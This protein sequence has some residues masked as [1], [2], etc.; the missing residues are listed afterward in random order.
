MGSSR[1]SRA[2]KS[3]V[4]NA[5]AVAHAAVKGYFKTHLQFP[6]LVKQNGSNNV[7]QISCEPQL[8]ILQGQ[9]NE[10][11]GSSRSNA[12]RHKW[13]NVPTPARVLWVA[14]AVTHS[15][16]GIHV[17]TRAPLPADPRRQRG[18]KQWSISLLKTKGW[19]INNPPWTNQWFLFLFF[20]RV[21][22]FSEWA[23][24]SRAA[25]SRCARFLFVHGSASW[26]RGTSRVETKTETKADV[27]KT[28]NT[29][30]NKCSQ[31]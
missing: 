4:G 20:F 28:H 21:C 7:T 26:Q 15:E 1:R 9:I 10:T 18:R 23:E 8:E 17:S 6:V 16:L 5:G 11:G 19:K 27:D 12:P 24:P 22:W 3:Q 13:S 14:E 2:K 29:T 31:K 30:F 25:E